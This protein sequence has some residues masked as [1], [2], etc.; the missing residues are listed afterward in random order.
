MRS[1]RSPNGKRERRLAP[2]LT[3]CMLATAMLAAISSMTAAANGD[4]NRPIDWRTYIYVPSSDCQDDPVGE[5]IL[6]RVRNS[7]AASPDF[8][9]VDDILEAHYILAI[10]CAQPDEQEENWRST[11]SYTITALDFPRSER[12]QMFGELIATGIK[13]CGAKRVA[14]CSDEFVSDLKTAIDGWRKLNKTHYP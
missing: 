14:E 2:R 1:T 5:R 6:F 10:V 11:H 3:A 8:K 12:V 9:P 7:L 4:A 13:R